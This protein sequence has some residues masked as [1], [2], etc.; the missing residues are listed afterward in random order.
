MTTSLP[1][2]APLRDLAAATLLAGMGA[3]LFAVVAPP[4]RRAVHRS[5]EA[6]EIHA[7]SATLHVQPSRGIVTFTSRDHLVARDVA[8]TLRAGE[9]VAP[10]I[11]EASPDDGGSATAFEGRATLRVHGRDLRARVVGTVD[12]PR[13]AFVVR[14]DPEGLW[15][16]GVALQLEA[17]LPLGGRRAFVSG[18]GDMA[19][20]G[21][22]EGAVAMVEAE[23]HPLVVASSR[24]PVRATV[25]GQGAEGSLELS[26]RS[27]TPASGPVAA[28]TPPSSAELSVALATS[29]VDAWALAYGLR[30][31]GTVNVAGQ[32]T[33]L[34]AGALA[35]VTGTNGAGGPLVRFTARAAET[36]HV[37]VPAD[38]RSFF[39]T[40]S[41][42][43]GSVVT[44][45]PALPERDVLLLD[46]TPASSLHVRV[47]DSDDKAIPARVII[48][49]L[50]GTPD[51]NFGPDYRASGAGP[52]LDVLRGDMTTP[53][54]AGHYRV[55]ATRGLA[56]AVDQ[57]E[58]ELVG[59]RQG[60]VEL[61]LAKLIGGTASPPGPFTNTVACDVHV[62][63]RPSFDTPVTPEDRVLS[64]VSAGIDFAVPTEHNLVGDYGPSLEVLGLDEGEGPRLLWV[65][66]VEVTTYTPRF[67]HFGVFPYPP[68][69]GVPPYRATTPRDVFAA[70]RRVAG[71]SAIVQVN[72][73]RLEG[74]IGFFQV[75]GNPVGRGGVRPD[76]DTLEVYNGY[77]LE[78]PER[79]AEVMKDWFAL[80]DAGW[81]IPATGSSDA[82]RI[83]Y[84]WAGY[85]RTVAFL[86]AGSLWPP[87]PE[88]VVA[89]LK[90]GRSFVT[91]GP[92]LAV[93]VEGRGPGETWLAGAQREA[94][95][96]VH[97]EAA[98]W[99]DVT[100]VDVLVGGRVVS[101]LAV[102]PPS[103][104]PV[105]TR[106]DR[107]LV[108]PMPGSSTHVI[109]LARGARRLDDVLPFMPV[110]PLAFTNPVWVQHASAPR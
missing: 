82:H 51:P 93:S 69:A 47:R 21:A 46:V 10:L 15:P 75:K 27:P 31:L 83:Q 84:H 3:T 37:R 14:A 92:Y 24:G 91:S 55:S 71:S 19:D 43:G 58:V 32:V 72:H 78:Y 11:V 22:A 65:P 60:D 42:G 103:S 38:V 2:G 6:R 40:A 110:A 70:S 1:R 108:V 12:G 101:H 34:P 59:G 109:L 56:F 107:D 62:H 67:G 61:H 99:V 97:V 81:F 98:P 104:P 73:P 50:A 94:R 87:D 45:V 80:L 5:P 54:P 85:P 28:G 48:R 100:E 53:L 20:L 25:R 57:R 68:D 77:D 30:G 41:G 52:L 96:H 16:T 29:S 4:P 39:A 90:A 49:G 8:F 17:Q 89:A 33:G 26:V 95:V 36:F 35:T 102:D 13:S 44:P 64:L 105:V 9:D 18:V 76:F 88:A 74:G 106:L 23:P 63:A 86:P 7:Q 66:G 79:V